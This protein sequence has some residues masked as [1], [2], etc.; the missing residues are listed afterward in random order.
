M[1][2]NLSLKASLWWEKFGCIK[3]IRGARGDAAQRTSD[4]GRLF[5]LLPQKQFPDSTLSKKKHVVWARDSY[6]RRLTQKL[7]RLVCRRNMPTIWFFEHHL[8]RQ[9]ENSILS[10]GFWRLYVHCRK[11]AKRAHCMRSET[12]VFAFFGALC[13]RNLMRKSLKFDYPLHG[14]LWENKNEKRTD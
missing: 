8:V 11:Y 5:T 12:H 3:F 4:W 10:C 6:L 2:S 13:S 9:T 1:G 14:S 7:F